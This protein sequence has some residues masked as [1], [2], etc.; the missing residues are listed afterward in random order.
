M[1]KQ[2]QLRTARPRTGNSAS[3]VWHDIF[4]PEHTIPHPRRRKPRSNRRCPT[5]QCCL[6]THWPA[7]FRGGR[8]S[9]SLV[10]ARYH[11][12]RDIDSQ[13]PTCMPVGHGARLRLAYV[14]PDQRMSTPAKFCNCFNLTNLPNRNGQPKGSLKGPS[15]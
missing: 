13:A 14:S 3:C 11:L 5:L 12:G 2:S 6:P 9:H 7:Y 10:L 8:H 15:P 1:Q 4:P